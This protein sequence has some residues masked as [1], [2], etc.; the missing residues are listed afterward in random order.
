[1][2]TD[3]GDDK[4][5]SFMCCWYFMKLKH[6]KAESFMPVVILKQLNPTEYLPHPNLYT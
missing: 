5:K 4:E 6:L 3:D 1:M 2:I